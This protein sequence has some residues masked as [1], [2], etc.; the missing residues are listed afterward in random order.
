MLRQMTEREEA[1]TAALKVL[2]G[3]RQDG[4]FIGADQMEARIDEM[5]ARKRRAHGVHD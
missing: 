5:V 2:L 4:E 3:R 1:Q